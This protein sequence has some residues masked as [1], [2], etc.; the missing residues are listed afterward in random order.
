M[1]MMQ[2]MKKRM[3]Q[4]MKISREEDDDVTIWNLKLKPA[5]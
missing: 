2:M 5:S 1:R 4:M 3:V